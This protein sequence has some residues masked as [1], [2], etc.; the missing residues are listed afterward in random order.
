[1]GSIH[2]SKPSHDTTYQAVLLLVCH[3][4]NYNEFPERLGEHMPELALVTK[5]EEV[6][7]LWDKQLFAATDSSA[8][9]SDIAI[10]VRANRRCKFIDALVPFDRNK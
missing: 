3:C 9:K 6:P 7:I 2:H 1:M 5:S 8:N 10:K 4:C